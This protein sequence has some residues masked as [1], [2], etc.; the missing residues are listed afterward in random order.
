MRSFHEFILYEWK[1]KLE[2]WME[3][4]FKDVFN[5]YLTKAEPLMVLNNIS[6]KLITKKSII[7]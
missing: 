5:V 1:L 2:I 6:L 3:S 4:T 7:L